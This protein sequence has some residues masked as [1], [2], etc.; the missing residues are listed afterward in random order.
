MLMT[1]QP[2]S[3]VAFRAMAPSAKASAREP[4]RTQAERR[5]TTQAALLDAT[6]DCLVEYGYVHTTTARVAERAGFSRGAQVHHFP[7]KAALVTA[8]VE[9]LARRRSDELRERVPDLPEGEAKFGQM[10]DL[11][12]EA[13]SG[14]VFDATLE[15]WVA[16]RTDAELRTAL[17]R[18]EREVT[19][20]TLAQIDE[21]FGEIARE[22]GFRDDVEFALAAI[23]GVA[24]LRAAS[25]ERSPA[26]KRRWAAARERLLRVLSARG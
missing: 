21:A 12:W 25:G 9:H 16:A 14:P 17:V 26:V 2:R 4:R 20:D 6:I 18:L 1:A 24:L 5:A 11:L 23:R 15:L 13:H 22:P 19:R 10:L 8:A 3:Q 7:T